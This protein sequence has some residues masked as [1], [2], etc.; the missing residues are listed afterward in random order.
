M[1]SIRQG[2]KR[3]PRNAKLKH[4]LQTGQ[5]AD[6][7]C[8]AAWRAGSPREDQLGSELPTGDLV[9]LFGSAAT[10]RH[11]PATDQED[12]GKSPP[13]LP[14]VNSGRS[15]HL[16]LC[17]RPTGHGLIPGYWML[18]HCGWPAASC[19][20]AVCCLPEVSTQASGTESPG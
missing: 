4:C 2:G 12:R 20:V 1:D 8:R 5:Y 15:C 7:L 6:R 13:R 10:P 14:A 19:T 3:R 9:D 16:S 17:T 18:T 11:P